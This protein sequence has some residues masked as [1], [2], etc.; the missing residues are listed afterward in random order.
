MWVSTIDVPSVM[1][2]P[3]VERVVVVLVN[4][5]VV[6]ATVMRAPTM[7]CG[8]RR[9]QCESTYGHHS[10]EKC[11]HVKPPIVVNNKHV[12]YSQSSALLGSMPSNEQIF[13]VT[14]GAVF[15]QPECTS[16]LN[17]GQILH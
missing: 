5:A 1:M 16:N 2:T 13:S 14:A 10:N 11:S 15:D 4:R 7:F 9:T 3:A 6:P 8:S 12:S 17:V